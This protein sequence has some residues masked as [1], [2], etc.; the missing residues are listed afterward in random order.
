VQLKATMT[1]ANGSWTVYHHDDGHT[2]YDPTQP[3]A[4]GASAGW[5]S[6]TLDA[7]VYA[8]PLVYNGIVYAATLNNTVYALNQADGTQVWKW[9]DVNGAPKT[10]GWV[11]GAMPSQGILGTPVIDVAGG[12]IYVAALFNSD[13]LYRVFG[14]NLATGAVQ[15]TAVLPNNLG[16]GFDWT[17][18]QQRGALAVHNGFVYVPFGGRAGDCGSYHGWIYA[19]STTN[20]TPVTTYYETPGNG[21][22]FW[23]A[24]GIVVDDSTGK[25][26]ATSGNAVPLTTPP[27]GCAANPN[28]TPVTENDAVVRLSSTLAHED[29]F[30]PSDWQANWCN[31]D[32]DL[33]SASP[34]LISP[35]LM[36]QSGKWG[37]G[38]LLNP[39]NL[40]GLDGQLYPTPKPA[41]YSEAAVCN[42]NN[43]TFGSF[44]YAAPFIYVSCEF[45][46]LVALSTNTGTPSFNPCDAACAA[47]DW[48][49]APS[50]NLGPPIVAGG[51]VWVI[52]INGTGLY[53]F[54]AATGAQ[55][56]HSAPFGVMHFV[57]PAEAGGQ[58]FVPAGTEIRE[59]NMNFA[60]N[61]TP[62]FTSYFS[63]FDKATAGM[64]GDNIHLLNT[65]VSTST[66]CVTLSGQASV[67]FTL[68]AGQET[69]VT[70]PAGTIGGPVLVQVMN[71]P[72]VLASQRVQYYQ[73]FNE[74]WAMNASQAAT[75]SYINWFDKAS[76]GMVGDNIH[77]LVPGTTAAN[78]TV[79]LAG[80]TPI[81]FSLGAGQE[82]Y[83]TF[84]HGTIG[85]PVTITADQPVLASQRVQ[86]YQS[87]NE[88]VARS[89]AQ[90]SATSYFNWFDRATAGMVGDN[91]HILVPG[92]T[93]ASVTLSLPG[94]AN[95]GPFMLGGGQETYVNFGPGHIGGPVT[96][97]STQ[98]VLASQRV[99]YY[100]SFNETASENATQALATSHIMWFDKA[101]AGMV[102]DNIHI[103]NTSVS[104]ANVTVSLPG[105]SNIVFPL[106]AGQET[107][108]TFLPGHIGG[109]VTITSSQP[110][111]AAQRVQYFQSFNEVPAA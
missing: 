20:G 104:T 47:P 83:V 60:C 36:F 52:D 53:A 87:F 30:V 51:A 78:V 50:N 19:V 74:V 33:G 31:N 63:W 96:V 92:A 97:T 29:S 44:A 59:F 76:A 95:I 5:T 108:V 26:F 38:F 72:P 67:P 4:V 111:L 93:A 11:C 21:A 101:T 56:Y 61:G 94:A 77:V 89:A 100:S 109:P 57:T 9:H 82:T 106:Q 99:Q 12:R 16:T 64:V 37:T 79:S 35:S 6:A 105:A 69:Y 34:L 8:E 7:Q 86:Y 42:G 107:Y 49:S 62:L 13:S 3:Q 18:Q 39:A 81:V 40:G 25:V 46:G 24:S 15:L 55:L 17:I 45:N 27:T 75:T 58:V 90:A 103:L 10:G 80:A 102:G 91:I 110:L 54:N 23:N 98:P 22:G 1:A 14:L 70:L 28:G 85:G 68:P 65:G 73:S 32:A 41:T 43:S 88:V 66:G 71:G 2:G 84:P 48:R